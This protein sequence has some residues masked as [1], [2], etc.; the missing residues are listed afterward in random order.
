MKILESF[1]RRQL[2]PRLIFL[3]C[4]FGTLSAWQ[5]SSKYLRKIAEERFVARTT[6][7]TN[8][9]VKRIQS[10]RTILRG[11]SAL[12]AA[13]KDISREQWRLYAENLRVKETHPGIQG[14]GFSKV[15]PPAELKV[16]I[17][18][19]RGERFPDYTVRPEGKR[20]IYTS[21]IY[22]EPFDERNRRAFGYDMFS[23]PV[24]RAAMEAARDADRT[25]MSGKVTLVQET[26][27]DVQAGFL[28]YVPVYK[29]G[30]PDTTVAERRSALLGYVYSPFRMKNLMK[31]IIGPTVHD[32]DLE[33]YDGTDLTEDALMFDRNEEGY[34]YSL[35]KNSQRL[36]TV[37]TV[38]KL[39]GHDWTLYYSSLPTFEALYE[40]HVPRG[41]LFTGLVISL[42]LFLVIRAQENARAQALVMLI[43]ITS[44]RDELA[45]EVNERKAVEESLERVMEN[46]ERS[47]KELE[48]FAYI[49]SHDLQEPLHKIMAFG[50]LL[51]ARAYESLNEQNRD[52]VNRM[53]KAATRMR[54]LIDDLLMYSRVTTRGKE[55]EPVS[56]S[57]ALSDA[58]SVLDHRIEESRGE[59][60]V[61]TLPTVMADRMQM[62]QL[63]QNLIGNALKF[64][65]S[66]L[67]PLIRVSG[68]TLE[69]GSAEISIEDNGIGFDEK[70]LDRIYTLF[71]R[72]HGRDEYEGTGIGLALCSKIVERHRGTI[73]AQ[74]KPGEGATFIVTLPHESKG[75]QT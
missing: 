75:V 54:Q 51:K 18:Q 30:M 34:A 64:R 12:F 32:Y 7:I 49:A 25:T 31:G 45:R 13:Q 22:L 15:I 50:D 70:Y 28:L 23:E 19:V 53:Q 2:V 60:I 48:Q 10:N 9:I 38:V 6:E 67:P 35:S 29:K 20:E 27:K 62:A 59:V 14:F 24:R 46:L 21:I 40:R 41:I 17:A 43:D 55:F 61:G 72:L 3:L 1:N 63:F 56:L 33:I 37:K 36:F 47:N 44:S 65:K 5:A 4:L 42:L 8:Q 16:H 11:G 74:S 26:D 52:Y 66:D 69:D 57:D 39:Y 71:Q 58:L 73:T 68:R